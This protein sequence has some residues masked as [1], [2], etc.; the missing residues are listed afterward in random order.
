MKIL[1]KKNQFIFQSKDENGTFELRIHKN[2]SQLQLET[3]LDELPHET[4]IN[5]DLTELTA[6]RDMI[7]K[8]LELH[9]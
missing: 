4:Y 6:I 1:N 2:C 5:I 3:E 9:K 8:V 7:N